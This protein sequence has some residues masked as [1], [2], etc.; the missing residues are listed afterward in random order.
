MA[1]FR[2]DISGKEY[3]DIERV[4]GNSIKTP[5]MD[6]I[7][8]DFPNFNESCNLVLTELNTFRTAYLS[9]TMQKEMG[10]LDEL[11]RTVLESLRDQTLLAD[12]LEETSEPPLTFG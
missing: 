12:R 5:L 6:F 1:T 3:P 4:P 7:R 8:R 2:S 10:A 11:S 9:E